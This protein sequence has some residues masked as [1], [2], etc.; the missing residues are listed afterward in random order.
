MTQSQQAPRSAI[1]LAPYMVALVAAGVIV[2]TIIL[3]MLLPGRI[4][5]PGAELEQTDRQAN[6]ALVEAERDWQR[7]REQQGGFTA[8]L[9]QA[10]R[11]WEAQRKQ[12]SP[13]GE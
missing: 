9:I 4:S 12:L 10:E 6:P 5:L 3:G 2:T 8:P 7:Q 1:T 11:D 13:D